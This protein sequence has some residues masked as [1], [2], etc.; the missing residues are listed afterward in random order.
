MIK[1][2]TQIVSWLCLVALVLPSVLFLTG[3]L[4]S[5]DQVKLI[6]LIATVIWFVSTPLWMWNAQGK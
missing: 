6:M 4:A 5:L 3:A 1:T 2:V